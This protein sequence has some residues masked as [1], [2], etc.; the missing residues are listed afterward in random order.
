ME[1]ALSDIAFKDV[2]LHVVSSL[3]AFIVVDFYKSIRSRDRAQRRQGDAIRRVAAAGDGAATGRQS[4][5]S[6]QVRRSWLSLLFGWLFLFLFKLVVKA[7]L[8][9]LIAGLAIGWLQSKVDVAAA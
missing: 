5:A 3:A 2:G 9:L 8:A 1:F 6:P 7:T 4:G